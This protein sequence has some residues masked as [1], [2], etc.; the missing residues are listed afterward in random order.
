MTF[1]PSSATRW[2]FVAGI[3]GLSALCYGACWLALHARRG[4]IPHL[5]WLAGLFVL[6]GGAMYLSLGTWRARVIVDDRGLQWKGGQEPADFMTWEQIAKLDYDRK[7]RSVIVRVVEKANG[8]FY[9][10][11]F[12]SK[13]LYAV[14]RERL[15]PLPEDVEKALLV[16]L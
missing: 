7:S 4:V 10:L 16:T 8:Q 3:A 15:N 11:P 5:E 9:P 2:A 1:R 6:L 13:E 14:L 12:M